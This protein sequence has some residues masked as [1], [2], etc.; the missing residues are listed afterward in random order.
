MNFS[1]LNVNMIEKY[2][3]TIVTVLIILAIVLP[4]LK[5]IISTYNDFQ[6]KKEDVEQNKSGIDIELEARFDTLTKLKSTVQGYVKHENDTFKE[7]VQFRRGM[8]VKDM[9]NAEKQMQDAVSQINLVAEQY[10]DL[11]AS[12][13]FLMLQ[14][15]IAEGEKSL[16][17]ARRVYNASV[18]ILNKKVVN[19]P[20]SLI[21]PLAK[22][23]KADLFEV[24]E[25][26]S[27]DV[28]MTF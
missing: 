24:S 3:G 8:S 10:P 4:L 27:K 26:K 13:N 23:T 2:S 21:A 1:T 28:D 17:V 22:A 14:N 20:S 6:N 25:G 7:I 19:F 16:A 12:Q 18:T 5:W 9:A 15:S 11:K